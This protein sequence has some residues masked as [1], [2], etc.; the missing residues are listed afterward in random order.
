MD[1]FIKRNKGYIVINF[2]NLTDATI[3]DRP[4]RFIV[5]SYLNNKIINVHLHDPG[6]LEELIYTGNHMLIRKAKGKK[7]DYSVTFIKN[8]N[9]YTFND[10]RFHSE[11]ASK[12][13]KDGYEKEVKVDDSRIDFKYGNSFIEVKSCTLVENGIAKFPDAQTVRGKK[14][15]ITLMNLMKNHYDSYVLFLIFNENAKCFLPNAE[16]DLDFSKTFYDA[17]SHDVKFKFLV[18]YY[19]N[20]SIYFKNE[21]K[22]CENLK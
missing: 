7:T 1:P 12:F 17:Y 8:N 4:N 15:L 22:L 11:I 16:R 13:I 14:H 9:V 18:F 2:Q 6:R 21:I 19:K 10:A 3:I 20:N 5:R